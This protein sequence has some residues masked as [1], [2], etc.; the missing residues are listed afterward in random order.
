[1]TRDADGWSTHEPGASARCGR[2]RHKTTPAA[3]RRLFDTVTPPKEQEREATSASHDHRTD[4]DG[5]GGR[6]EEKKRRH[7]T[8]TGSSD[9]GCTVAGTRHLRDSTIVRRFRRGVDAAAS[10]SIEGVDDADGRPARLRL[11][12]RRVRAMA[13]VARSPSAPFIHDRAEWS[14]PFAGQPA[15][16]RR[17]REL[18]ASG[19]RGGAGRRFATWCSAA[20]WRQQL[21]GFW[22]GRCRSAEPAPSRSV[23]ACHT[24]VSR[25]TR[26]GAPRSFTNPASGASRS[27]ARRRT[28]R[29]ARTPP[30]RRA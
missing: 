8:C 18:R 21:D 29:L 19:G 4:V 25:R 24:A 5:R 11:H 7:S 6:A 16:A 27:T 26:A 22:R 17:R 15:V 30:A 2:E 3:D 10:A 20:C 12:A 23:R 28:A 14:A 13:A 1:V 9:H